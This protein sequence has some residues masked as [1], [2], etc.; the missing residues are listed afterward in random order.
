MKIKITGELNKFRK[1]RIEDRIEDLNNQIKAIETKHSVKEFQKKVPSYV[2][3]NYQNNQARK[4][5]QELDIA[6]NKLKKDI[7]E[8]LIKK[9]ELMVP[10]SKANDNPLFPEEYLKLRD[11]FGEGLKTHSALKKNMADL[12]QFMTK[13]QKEVSD[14]HVRKERLEATQATAE[15]PK[16]P[17]GLRKKIKRFKHTK[18]QHRSKKESSL[19][20]SENQSFS[21]QSNMNPVTLSEYDSSGGTTVSNIQKKGKGLG[22]IIQEHMTKKNI[23][24]QEL[25]Q[26]QRL[27]EAIK[28]FRN[29][30]IDFNLDCINNGTEQFKKTI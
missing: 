2:K 22:R 5:F 16:I 18:S 23:S 26:K 15:D 24:A 11:Q 21:D 27:K 12:Q 1:Q 4:A 9:S 20:K 30:A 8:M 28:N 10:L 29:R 6:V 7:E 17:L 3:Q 14:L 19:I 25:M 13:L